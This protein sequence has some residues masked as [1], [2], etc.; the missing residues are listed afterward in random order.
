MHL[1]G[2]ADRAQ[3]LKAASRA[4]GICL[5]TKS[6]KRIAD[7]Y[8]MMQGYWAHYLSVAALMKKS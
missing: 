2:Y 1:L 6:V 3:L 4:Y 5:D 8:G 7:S